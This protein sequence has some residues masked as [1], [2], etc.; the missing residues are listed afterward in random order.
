MND[1]AV[2]KL[3]QEIKWGDSY[4]SIQSSKCKITC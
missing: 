1:N 3:V 4:A 2:N